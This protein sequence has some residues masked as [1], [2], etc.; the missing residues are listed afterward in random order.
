VTGERVLSAATAQ[1]T[2]GTAFRRWERSGRT[3]RTHP[4]RSA[5]AASRESPPQALSK[6]RQVE[7]A[8]HISPQAKLV[9]L[10]KK[11]CNLR[12]ILD[13]PPADWPPERKATYLDC[14]QQVVDGM[15]GA[16][17]KDGPIVRTW[18]FEGGGD[19]DDAK[20]GHFHVGSWP[21]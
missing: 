4:P 1:L 9:Q 11:I 7:H 5:R 18:H 17:P 19:V 15:P 2:S 6:Q 12:D 13:S 8:S 16:L 3:C 10:A 20:T 21:S 14:A